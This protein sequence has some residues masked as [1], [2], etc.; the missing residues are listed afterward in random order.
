M[1]EYEVLLYRL[2]EANEKLTG[3]LSNPHPGC[4]TWWDALKE[5]LDNLQKIREG[6][7]K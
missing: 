5:V 6:G 7:D 1:R 3:L 2:R 4:F